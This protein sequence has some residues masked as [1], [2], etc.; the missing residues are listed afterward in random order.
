VDARPLVASHDDTIDGIRHTLDFLFR[1]KNR[2]T[3][4][5]VSHSLDVLTVMSYLGLIKLRVPTDVSVVARQNDPIY[6]HLIPS[7]ATYKFSVHQYALRIS[8]MAAHLASHERT[9]HRQFYVAGE[10]S[11]G[12]SLTRCKS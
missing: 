4:L 10:F 3:A 5:F 11:P 1:I 12:E 6:E 9:P 8:R 2:P 7:I